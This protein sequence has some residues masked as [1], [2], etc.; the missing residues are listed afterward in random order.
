[1]ELARALC[2]LHN[3]NP[4]IIHRD[5]KPAN[6]LLNEDGHL[7]VVPIPKPKTRNLLPRWTAS[8]DGAPGRAGL[9]A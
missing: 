3:C 4:V 6:L 2:F 8:V 9:A 1:M 7:K 5:L